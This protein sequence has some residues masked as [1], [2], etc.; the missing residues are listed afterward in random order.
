MP[1]PIYEYQK[2]YM[3]K[4]REK[5]KEKI[6]TCN[7][8]KVSCSICNKQVARYSMSAHKKSKKHLLAAQRCAAGTEQNLGAELPATS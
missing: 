7:K 8:E 6:D 5:N 1:S 4:Y 3:E 2:K